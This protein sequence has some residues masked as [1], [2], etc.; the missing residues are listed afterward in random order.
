MLFKSFISRVLLFSAL[1]LGLFGAHRSA[2]AAAPSLT[3]TWA[4]TSNNEDGFR[5][6]RRAGTTGSYQHLVNV[7]ANVV[8]YTDQNLWNKTTYCYRV[9]AFNSGGNSAYSNED[10]ATTPAAAVAFSVS[11]SGSGSGT[12][13]SSPAGINCG[14]DCSESYVAGTVVTLTATAAS[15][16]TFAGWSGNA[17]CTDGVVTVNATMSCTATFNLA[18]ASSYTLTT[19]IVNQITSTGSAS[20]RVVSSPVGI[21]CGSDC[22]EVYTSGKV[23]SLTAI[24]GTNSKFTGWTGHSDCT[25]GSVTMNAN[26]T[27][28][29]NFSVDA[30]TV[31]VKKKGKGR[32]RSA[33]SAIDCGTTCTSSVVSGATLS[34]SATPEPGYV[35]SGWSDGCS[36]TG[37]CTVTASSSTVVTANFSSN[38]SDRIGVYRP[39]T[40][41]WFL[42]KNGNGA[43]DGCAS[44]GCV[45]PFGA[46]EGLPI[47]GDWTGSGVTKL[48]LFVS[49]SAQWFL[50]GNGNGLWDGCE[51]DICSETYGVSTDLP[52]I[53]RWKTGVEDR[54]AIFRPTEKRWHLDLNGNENLDKCRIDKCPSFNIYQNGDLPVAGDWA[55]RGRTDLGL[56]RPSTGEWFL[57]T[58]S[59][60]TWNGC[61]RDLCIGS[62]GMSGDI[63][64]T[65]DW[66]GT[67]TTKIGV[68]R[69]S[70]GEWFLD[71][72]GNGRWDGPGNDL[73]VS[74][75]GQSGDL[76]VVGKW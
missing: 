31:T 68:F 70:T 30:G 16:S 8:T 32:V 74:G 47:V 1:A 55:G 48:G 10:C 50:D 13:T 57:N 53:G 15:G 9:L 61:K 59:N 66:N 21:D 12:I 34:L 2:D 73:Y 7:A 44:D 65:G 38:L 35:F 23:V 46:T 51:I 33:S 69:P 25:D 76:P 37:S 4:D 49:D 27:C 63:P 36:G 67:G 29:A 5:I 45:Q 42:D 28:T 64:V 54:L 3:I 40:G 6:E 18:T 17:D 43:W 14:S 24:A 41:E 39:S 11:R 71:F 22:A 72:N 20:G 62:F 52:A 60:R 75:Y 58:N 56:F 26:K 19:T